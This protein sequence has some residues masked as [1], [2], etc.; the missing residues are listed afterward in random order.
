MFYENLRDDTSAVLIERFGQTATLQQE[1]NV[2][3]PSTGDTVTSVSS[4]TVT[5]LTLPASKARDSFREELVEK[6]DQFVLMSAKETAVASVV[7][8]VNDKLIIGGATF[9]VVGLSPVSPAGIDV[10]YKIGV[11][12][13]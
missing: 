12:R 1:T 10:I 3:S 9:A 13:S 6:F 8:T 11:A 5:L 2:Y 4:L 7:P